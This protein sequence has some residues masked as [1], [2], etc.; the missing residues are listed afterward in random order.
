MF[1]MA[2]HSLDKRA[3]RHVHSFTCSLVPTRGASLTVSS[4]SLI[5]FFSFLF[6]PFLFR[7]AWRGKARQ[8][9]WQA[10]RL[11]LKAQSDK[12][13]VGAPICSVVIF[14]AAQS[15]YFLTQKDARRGGLSFHAVKSCTGG[16]ETS[17]E[18]LQ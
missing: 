15:H 7:Q 12:L 13:S 2:N 8:A 11:R 17:N 4:L 5:L 14:P 6:F 18:K 1:R 9:S 3:P 10:G 16:E